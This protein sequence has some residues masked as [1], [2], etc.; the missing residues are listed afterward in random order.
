MGLSGGIDSTLTALIAAEALGSENVIGVAMPGPY[1]SAG[2]VRDARVLA[3]ALGI[4]F[5]IIPI[6]TTFESFREDF[7]PRL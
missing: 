4:R 3:E 2:S 6:D 5:E 7:E 1:S